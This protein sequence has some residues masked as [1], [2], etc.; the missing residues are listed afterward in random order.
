MCTKEEVMNWKKGNDA[1]L[2]LNYFPPTKSFLPAK[3]I[4]Y[5]PKTRTFIFWWIDDRYLCSAGRRWTDGI[6]ALVSG[7]HDIYSQRTT[8]WKNVKTDAKAQQI[9]TD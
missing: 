7:G 6:F 8:A 3:P 4:L 9:K 2:G 5:G 1:D